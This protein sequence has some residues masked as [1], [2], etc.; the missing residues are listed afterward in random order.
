MS[1]IKA[2]KIK[3]IVQ[4]EV[5]EKNGACFTPSP[6]THFAWGTLTDQGAG[7]LVYTVTN[8]ARFEKPWS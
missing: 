5:V 8:P 7:A 6:Q 2:R 1:L 4:S 3:K